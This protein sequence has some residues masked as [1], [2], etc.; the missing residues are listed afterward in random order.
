MPDSNAH[1]LETKRPVTLVSTNHEPRLSPQRKSFSNDALWD[2]IRAE[3]EMVAEHEP[4]LT[5]LVLTSILNCASFEDAIGRRIASR[6]GNSSVSAD[7]IAD[8][9]ARAVQSDPGMAHALRADILAVV[10]RDPAASRVVEPFL[11]FKGFHAIE[12]HRLAHF[13]WK[14][15]QTDLALYLQSRSSDVFQTDIHPA[16]SFGRGIFLDHATGFVAGATAVIDDDVS[17]LQ[18]VT[19]GGTGKNMGDRHPKVRSGV[20]IGA[21]A[22]ILGNIEIGRCSRIAAGSV[23]LQSVPPKSTVAGVPARVVGAAGCADP[24]RDMNQLLSEL[25]YDAFSYSI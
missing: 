24:A 4:L 17:I 8:T 3:A 15:G 23:V 20:M 2:H 13:L 1:A 12:S 22:K 16:V 6:L 21:G 10:E 19:L 7:L 11:Y 18:N 14:K 5:T 9:F 25:A